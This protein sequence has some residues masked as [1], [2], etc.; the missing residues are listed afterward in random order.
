M[1]KVICSRQALPFKKPLRSMLASSLFLALLLPISVVAAEDTA[2]DLDNLAK[3]LRSETLDQNVNLLSNNSGNSN[4][5]ITPDDDGKADDDDKEENSSAAEVENQQSKNDSSANTISSSEDKGR[6][7]NDTLMDLEER[8]SDNARTE[9]QTQSIATDNKVAEKKSSW[10][11]L[12]YLL[13]GGLL[14]LLLSGIFLLLNNISKLKFENR[15]LAHKNATLKAKFDSQTKLI[16]TVK[17]E[18]KQ[19]RSDNINFKG[20]INEQQSSPASVNTDA[21]DLLSM[22]SLIQ[23]E[24]LSIED[25]TQSDRSQLASIFDNWLTTNR[26]NTKVD[27]LIPDHIQKKL[28]H[29][30]YAIELWGQGSGLDSVDITKNTMHTAVISLIKNVNE[31][32]AYC[33]IKPNSMS[34]LWKNKAWYTVE[35]A[36][37]T[38]KLTG[39]LLE[40]N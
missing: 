23:A 17:N 36:N 29:W 18:N 33:Y 8:A 21:S 15:D 34:S 20:A 30:H 5:S 38:L 2:K 12:E 31:G 19:L 35:K 6:S 37:G 4:A 11:S 28:K 9:T 24:T 26:G 10:M 32:Y 14:L 25:L 16:N 22:S 7:V 1:K 40:S 3:P 27:D 39:E 13:V